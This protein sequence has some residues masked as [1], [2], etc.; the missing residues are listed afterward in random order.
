MSRPLSPLSSPELNLQPPQPEP[1]RTQDDNNYKSAMRSIPSSPL[2]YTQL[3]ATPAK[4]PS[5][6]VPSSPFFSDLSNQ[7]NEDPHRSMSPKKT[8]SPVKSSASSQQENFDDERQRVQV[9]SSPRKIHSPAKTDPTHVADLS[10]R[11]SEDPRGSLSP[12]KMR[13]P[14]KNFLS[15]R[16]P[17]L[18]HE[19]SRPLSRNSPTKKTENGDNDNFSIHEDPDVDD[20][21]MTTGGPPGFDGMDDT[22]LSTFSA[23]PNADMTMFARLGQSPERHSELSPSKQLLAESSFNYSQRGATPNR[24]Q[25]KSTPRTVRNRQ[26]LDSSPPASPTP[27]RDRGADADDDTS[28]L[29]MDFTEQFNALASSSS[30]YSHNSPSKRGRVSPTKSRTEGDLTSY[31]QRGRTPSPAKYALS[32]QTPTERRQFAN[33]LDF[34][35]PPPPTPRSVPSITARE[36]ESLKSGYL[37]QISSLKATLSGREAEVNSLKEAVGDAERRVGEAQETL[38]DERGAKEALQSDKEEWEKRGNEMEKVL[39]TVKQEIMREERE[40][41]EVAQKLEESERK[42]EEAETK[43]AEAE[44]RVA[45]LRASVPASSPDSA[46]GTTKEVEVAVEKVARELHSLYKS[47]HETKV[48]ALKKSYEARWEKRV[49]GLEK[50]L[51]ELYKENE[52]LR[53]GRDATMS[54][55]IPGTVHQSESADK[56]AE[57]IEDA[58][59][60]E[61]QKARILGFAEELASLKRD[62]DQLINELE[63]ERVEKG[64]LVSAVEEMLSMSGPSNAG[65][66]QTSSSLEDFKSS[67][68]KASGMKPPGQAATIG[69]G[70]SRIRRTNPP[71]GGSLRLN[72]SYAGGTSGIARSGIM[73]NIER[74]GR[75]RA[76]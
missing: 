11:L 39:R 73:S 34:D 42:R 35:I 54:G 32:G 47:K 36:L 58:Q 14:T 13:S 5:R 30:S 33:L 3:D 43:A 8:R 17:P 62:N 66:R 44:T 45:G 71:G 52:E 24:Q 23:V 55:V 59:K 25:A 21:V 38:R 40:K 6:I 41:E 49:N 37:S 28:N 70:E 75:G 7:E 18:F 72:R 60:A 74:M 1:P 26:D 12:R 76:E 2:K 46:V 27:R 51:E 15:K 68:T 63:K 67:I 16:L 57:R 20:S 10:E 29:I 4:D 53:V 9:E 61:E 69:G 48:A 50:K 19:S 31:I 64:N 65:E 22:A 56:E